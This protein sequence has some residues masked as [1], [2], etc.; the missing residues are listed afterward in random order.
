VTAVCR[1]QQEGLSD[2]CRWHC[3]L[4]WLLCVDFIKKAWVMFAGDIAGC[5]DCCV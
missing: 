2:V 3:W 4:L 1:L 5:C